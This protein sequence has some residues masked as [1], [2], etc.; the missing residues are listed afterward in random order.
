VQAR[1][2]RAK[3]QQT[4]L[5]GAA[6]D[7][8]SYFLQAAKT[9]EETAIRSGKREGDLLSYAQYNQAQALAKTAPIVSINVREN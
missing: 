9:F 6:E 5:G 3:L 1:Q 8:D 2:L 4:K 7:P